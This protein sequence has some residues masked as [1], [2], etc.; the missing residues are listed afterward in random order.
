MLQ[1]IQTGL[2]R[3]VNVR[4]GM[5]AKD[6]RKRPSPVNKPTMVLTF[7]LEGVNCVQMNM[8]QKQFSL[9]CGASKPN[10]IS[11]YQ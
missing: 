7:G 10:S 4:K 2:G 9:T 5:I 6:S 8:A 3:V 11:S 1:G